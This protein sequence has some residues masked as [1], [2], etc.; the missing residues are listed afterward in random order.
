MSRSVFDALDRTWARVASSPDA[1]VALERW[2][3]DP[4]LDAPDLDTLVDRVWSAGKADADRAHAALAA[5][6]PSDPVAARVL[7]QVLRPGLRSLGRRLALGGAFEDVDHDLLALAWERIRT[8]R[9][10]RR[11]TAV[12][13]N[14]LLD[15]RKHYVR[16]VVEP[17]RIRLEH[18][19]AEMWPSA[20]SAEH[21]AL[22]AF[23]PSLRRAH[24]RLATAVDR[25]KITATSAAV[26]WRTRVQ[27][28]DDAEVAA[29]LGVD[30]RTLQR[31]RQRAERQLAKAS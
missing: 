19:P 11:P 13:A 9:V 1:A 3:T 24:E 31:R 23:G 15:V 6:A 10:D 26:V 27:Q 12:A 14:I 2:R 17:D 25:G 7:L 4:A 22:D 28:H 20:P 30:V 29:E 5:R 21:E 18:I 8:Y 16:T